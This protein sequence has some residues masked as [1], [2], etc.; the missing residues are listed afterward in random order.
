MRLNEYE[1]PRSPAKFRE[2]AYEDVSGEMVMLFDELN[3]PGPDRD[4]YYDYME[5]AD[6]RAFL[7][8]LYDM[9][10]DEETAAKQFIEFCKDQFK[11]V[12]EDFTMGVEG[13]LGLNQ[14]IPHGGPGK[15]VLPKPLFDPNAKAV[16]PKKKDDEDTEKNKKAMEK[17]KRVI[18]AAGLKLVSESDLEGLEHYLYDLGF[19]WDE[20]DALIEDN[21]EFV[22]KS[23]ADGLSYGAIAADLDDKSVRQ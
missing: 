23:L 8:K 3:V 20:V 4:K 10:T 21:Q 12:K 5:S 19:E 17:A 16:P 6:G 9:W 18:E 7:K 11:Q 14:G 2:W 13:P 1:V 22:D 15:G